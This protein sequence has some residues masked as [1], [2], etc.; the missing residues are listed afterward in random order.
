MPMFWAWHCPF[1]YLRTAS[2]SLE[3]E[4]KLLKNQE[5]F[6]EALGRDVGHVPMVTGL[7]QRLFLEVLRFLLSELCLT[8]S[9]PRDE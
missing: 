4:E 8:T 1:R 7:V 6:R 3:Q 9:S 5:V 2:T